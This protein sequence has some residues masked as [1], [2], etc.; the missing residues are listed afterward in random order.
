MNLELFGGGER[1][2]S[3][4][5]A[6]TPL[7]ERIRPQNLEEVVGQDAIVGRDGFLRRALAD[8]RLPSLV[9]WGPPGCGKTT[10]ARII[11]S[12]SDSFFVPFSAVTAGIKEIKQVMQDAARMRSSQGRRTLL[13]ID[14]IH[15]F[16]KA[17]QDAFLP[18]VERGEIT[19]IGATTENPS[20]EINGSLLSR[21]RVVV[22]EP[23]ALEGLIVVLQRALQDEE[24]GLGT[25]DIE[26]TSE[27]LESIAQLASGDARRALNLLELCVADQPAGSRLEAASV[28]AVSQRKV[29]LYDKAGE[30]HFNLI[31]AL[32]KSLRE[33][34]PDASLYWLR[35][36]LE[37]GEDP[38]YVARRMVRF[39][40]EDIGLADPQALQHS[41]AAWE[42]FERLGSPEGELAL[43]QA[44]LYLALA[45]KSTAVYR[46]SKATREVIASQP[47]EP[48]PMEIRNAPT[49][50]MKDVGYGKGY[51]YAPDTEEGVGGLECLPESLRGSRF[52]EPGEEGFEKELSVRLER[53]L[54]LR[55]DL[56]RE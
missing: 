26:V 49:E 46:A 33:S 23:L 1:A 28:A 4:S 8:N 15:R 36:M 44:V 54:Q 45:P 29:L 32:H 53:L 56:Q 17:Q 48:V 6:G 5:A 42:A 24:R 20:F 39:A 40:S 35:R 38:R 22:L 12:E 37:A 41:L 34:D 19:L 9:F 2:P 11:A 27:A 7:A 52:Y 18:Y 43:D 10:L 3:S 14:E 21:C 30:E 16:N 47:A 50:L 31:S 55:R 25:V 13:F 51:V